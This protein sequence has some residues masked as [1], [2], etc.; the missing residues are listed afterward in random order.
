MKEVFFDSEAIHKILIGKVA[1]MGHETK[2]AT[3]KHMLSVEY[4]Y[5]SKITQKE[6]A[7]YLIGMTVEMEVVWTDK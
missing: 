4:P 6:I 3:V 7:I 1:E 5:K 2:G